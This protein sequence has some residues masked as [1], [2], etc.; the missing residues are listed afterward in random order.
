MG[1][2]KHKIIV[3]VNDVIDFLNAPL[4]GKFKLSLPDVHNE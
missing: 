1:Y 3:G 2:Q 4:E